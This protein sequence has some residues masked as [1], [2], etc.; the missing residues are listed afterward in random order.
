MKYHCSLASLVAACLVAF[1]CGIGAA[2]QLQVE[3]PKQDV[4]LMDAALAPDGR[5]GVLYSRREDSLLR[6]FSL[7]PWGSVV[8]DEQLSVGEK[9]YYNSTQSFLRYDAAGQEH[10]FLFRYPD[11]LHLTRSGS[12]WMSEVVFSTTTYN[13]WQVRHRDG[14]FHVLAFSRSGT[15]LNCASPTN[16]LLY[17]NN[18]SGI[19]QSQE[20]ASQQSDIRCL[21]D[22][23]L[24]V[25]PQ[26]IAHLVY[27]LQLRRL[28]QVV[29]PAELYYQTNLSGAFKEDLV[30]ADAPANLDS[31]YRDLAIRMLKGQ[32]PVVAFQLHRNVI[33]GS[34]ASHSLGSAKRNGAGIWSLIT[35]ASS[36]DGYNGT[37]G[38]HFTGIQPDLAIDQTGTIRI[39]FS[40]LASSHV[41]GYQQATVGQI[42]MATDTGSGYTLET[43]FRQSAAAKEQVKT[44]RL[45]IPPDGSGFDIF[46][47]TYSGTSYPPPD[48]QMVHLFTPKSVPKPDLPSLGPIMLLLLSDS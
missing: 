47:V 36:S 27:S 5:A 45:L 28:M 6:L 24:T 19:W 48:Q 39:I 12:N 30:D 40:D 13:E 41:G 7:S 2:V 17:I 35:V 34:S 42:R 33:T 29:W 8:A 46:G 4:E 44:L 38:N 14:S 11:F 22:I 3:F 1:F 15:T 9:L 31:A 23:D 20:L 18:L 32:E 10:V 43:L 16:A 26:G 25:G 21:M 37:D